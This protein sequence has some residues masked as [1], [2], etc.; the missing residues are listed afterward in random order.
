MN[1]ISIIY[2]YK[3]IKAMSPE[4]RAKV[5][6]L[7]HSIRALNLKH[8][9]SFPLLAFNQVLAEHAPL[10]HLHPWPLPSTSCPVTPAPVPTFPPVTL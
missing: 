6:A 10:C 7:G 8:R 3:T 9:F 5:G 1:A 4:D 2:R